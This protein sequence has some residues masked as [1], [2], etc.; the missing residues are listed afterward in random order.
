MDFQ[1]FAECHSK[2]ICFPSRRINFHFKITFSIQKKQLAL[3]TTHCSKELPLAAVFPSLSLKVAF[4][5]QPY[6]FG[7]LDFYEAVL[8]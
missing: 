3:A 2:K 7:N 5:N 6:Q 4:A 8:P 1:L